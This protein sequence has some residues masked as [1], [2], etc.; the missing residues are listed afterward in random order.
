MNKYPMGGF[1][2]GNH[3]S[4]CIVCGNLFLGDIDAIQCEPCG[5]KFEEKFLD[6]NSES[7]SWHCS[8]CNK[9]ASQC[10]CINTIKK[11]EQ[12]TIEENWDDIV[13]K[14]LDYY[15][16]YINGQGL[17]MTEWLKKNYNPPI[18]K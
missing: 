4:N 14:W 8:T 7:T 6:K 12:E 16:T 15:N 2:P 17:K 13:K 5:G 18:K 10:I 1:A 11:I 9:S 3:S